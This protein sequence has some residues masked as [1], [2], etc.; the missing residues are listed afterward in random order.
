MF[1][2][3]LF[4]C[5]LS[6]VFIINITHLRAASHRA[7]NRPIGN[8][9]NQHMINPMNPICLHSFRERVYFILFSESNP[10]KEEVDVGVNS[11]QLL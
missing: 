8:V 7:I 5:T 11:E 10:R 9:Q 1:S 4:F 2:F 3:I 6:T